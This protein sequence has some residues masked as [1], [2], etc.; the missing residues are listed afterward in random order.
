MTALADRRPILTSTF[1]GR[2]PEIFGIVADG[3]E[4]RRPSDLVRVALAVVTVAVTVGAA[5][6]LGPLERWS[7]ELVDKMPGDLDPVFAIFYPWALVVV[8]GAVVV[9]AVVS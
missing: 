4:R 8:A 1:I 7:Q 9:A 2:R 3:A 5:E 6:W